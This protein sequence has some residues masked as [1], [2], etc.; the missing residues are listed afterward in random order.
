MYLEIDRKIPSGNKVIKTMIIESADTISSGLF[1]M[2]VNKV[3]GSVSC[4]GG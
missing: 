4:P 3:M 1:A 2:M